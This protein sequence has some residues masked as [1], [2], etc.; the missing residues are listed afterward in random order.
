LQR[1]NQI[2]QHR[3]LFLGLTVFFLL[4]LKVEAQNTD[5]DWLRKINSSGSK[6]ADKFHGAISF[7]VYPAMIITPSAVFTDGLLQKDTFL[8]NAGLC[9]AAGLALNA[10]ITLATKYAINRDRPY[11]T[12]PDLQVVKTENTK[13][14]CSSNFTNPIA[15]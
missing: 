5:I 3:F 6:H 12:Y 9:I 13:C 1:N 2:I 15:S 8:I 7:S 14:F 4:S 11:I 10:G